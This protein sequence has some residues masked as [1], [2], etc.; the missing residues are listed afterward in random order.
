MLA[1]KF[2]VT[3]LKLTYLNKLPQTS[4]RN[5]ESFV[6]QEK[7]L[8]VSEHFGWPENYVL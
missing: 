3:K 2:N 8:K 1:L 7:Q 6:A 4:K 5:K